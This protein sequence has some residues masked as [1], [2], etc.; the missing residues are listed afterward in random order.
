M[1]LSKEAL[2]LEILDIFFLLFKHPEES[3]SA[4]KCKLPSSEAHSA[5]F[6]FF[7]MKI[8]TLWSCLREDTIPPGKGTL[9]VHTHST[10]K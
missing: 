1:T 7:N 4:F 5:L 3:Q 8:T 9:Y 2:S 10:F 6:F